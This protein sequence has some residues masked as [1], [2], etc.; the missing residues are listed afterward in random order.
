MEISHYTINFTG[1]THLLADTDFDDL[2]VSGHNDPEGRYR[3]ILSNLPIAALV[4][5]QDPYSGNPLHTWAD[6]KTPQDLLGYL[7]DVDGEDY[8]HPRSHPFLMTASE[9]C[10]CVAL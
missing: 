10:N 9:R 1:L 3:E 6:S 7:D 4:N 8:N 5:N 2:F